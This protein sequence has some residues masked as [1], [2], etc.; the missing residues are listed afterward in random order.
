MPRVQW[1][2]A[3][4]I[5]D[6]FSTLLVPIFNFVF[7]TPPSVWEACLRYLGDVY[8]SDDVWTAAYS[9]LLY[10][11]RACVLVR[12][13]VWAASADD[14]EHWITRIAAARGARWSGTEGV[15]RWGDAPIR[16]ERLL[17]RLRSL[18]RRRVAAVSR[19]I[20]DFQDGRKDNLLGLD[21]LDTILTTRRDDASQREF[22][23]VFT[24]FIG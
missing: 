17:R 10:Y 11:R 15:G 8:E 5:F 9:K 7:D 2:Y 21:L 13:W 14:P 18:S 23:T 12:Q 24:V 20:E 19:A 22:L 1:A 16:W 4:G 3:P 6:I